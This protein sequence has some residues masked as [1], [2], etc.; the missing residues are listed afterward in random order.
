LL[1]ISPLT[2]QLLI[3]TYAG[4]AI[5]SGVL[6]E[7]VSLQ[8]VTGIAWDPSGNIVI[9]DGTNNVLRRIGTNGIITTIAGTGA[10][11]F[12][13]DGGSALSALIDISNPAVCRYD[14]SVNLYFFDSINY[15]IRR[16]DPNGIITTVAGNGQYSVAGLN[17]ACPATSTAIGEVF[18]LAID[19]SGNIFFSE[20]NDNRI[21][22]VSVAGK[23]EVFLQL[24]PTDP[25]EPTF[26]PVATD[27]Q[28]NVYFFSETL[29]PLTLLEATPAGV[30]STFATFPSNSPPSTSLESD[31]AGNI[32]TYVNGQLLRY[33]SLFPSATQAT[34]TSPISDL[35]YSED[36]RRSS[37]H[38]R[39]NRDLRL[40]P[41]FRQRQNGEP[42]KPCQRGRRQSKQG[43]GRRLLF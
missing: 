34:S 42:G 29:F 7:N 4:G 16:I 35:H 9:A 25:L 37:Q 13:G 24:P 19:P 38:L 30:I 32:Y 33:A 40:W 39:R 8:N 31:L 22:R 27:S 23:L 5:R 15:R 17:A 1:T 10:T 3:D 41:A 26:T 14:A 2:A 11:G 43:L 18:D 12:A 21:F 20:S 36:Q 6:A 28:G